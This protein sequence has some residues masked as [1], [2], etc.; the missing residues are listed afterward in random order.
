MVAGVL[1]DMAG[2]L[3]DM[4]AAVPAAVPAA[5]V[6]VAAAAAGDMTHPTARAVEFTLR[7]PY[8]STKS[9]SSSGLLTGCPICITA[10]TGKEVPR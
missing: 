6:V 8:R 10:T 4:A 2:V 7:S 3:L 1:L 9:Q 5:M